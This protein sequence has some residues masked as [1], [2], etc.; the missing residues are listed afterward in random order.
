MRTWL[1]DL[2][3]GVRLAVGGGRTSLVRFVLS[4]IGVSIAVAVLL[5]GA[6]VQ[7]AMDAHDERLQAMIPSST[8]VPGVD[9][10]LMSD[11]PSA[12]R[13]QYLRVRYVHATGDNAPT[14][15]GLPAP[16][17]AGETYVSPALAELLASPD[18]GLLRPRFGAEIAGTIE[19]SA[20]PQLEDLVAY[21]GVD[22]ETM[23]VNSREVYGFGDDTLV[24]PQSAPVRMYTALGAVVFLVPVFVFLATSTR[25]AGAERDRRMAAVRLVGAGTRQVRRITAAESLVSAGAGLAVGGVLFALLRPYTDGLQLL[26]VR[27]RASDIVPDPLPVVLIVVAV[28][29]V[30]F[31]AA[32]FSLRR[33]AI[34]P[35][36]VVRQARPTRR[37]L[38]WRVAVVALGVLLLA[39]GDWL[40]YRSG[41]Y[42][43]FQAYRVAG[44]ALVLLGVPVLLPWVVEF[45][46]RRISGGAPSWQLAIR[47][48][49]LDSGTAG[50]VIAALVVVLAGA[51]AA[52]TAYTSEA[53]ERGAENARQESVASGVSMAT[54]DHQGVDRQAVR[55][56]LSGVTGV[57]SVHE[58]RRFEARVGDSAGD[59]APLG[60]TVLDCA[61]LRSLAI[62]PNCLDG[63]VYTSGVR[64]LPVRLRPGSAV[65]LL[66]YPDGSREVVG[67][68]TL[69]E[70]VESFDAVGLQ[71]LLH[72]PSV[73]A[74]PEALRGVDLPPYAQ[75]SSTVV[76]L[77][78]SRAAIEHVR[79]ALAPFAAQAWTSTA[80]NIAPPG[81]AYAET[82]AAIR[83]ALLTGSAFTLLLAGL[84]LLAVA[85]EQL[86]E[87]RRP[88]AML[89]AS[90]V[91]TGVIARSLLWQVLVPLALGVVIAIGTG[92]G[93]AAVAVEWVR[94]DLLV[95]WVSVGALAG[96][97]VLLSVLVTALTLPFLRSAIRFTSLRTE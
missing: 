39:G 96:I 10:L 66:S 18:G 72:I 45:A 43:A 41:S 57:R 30:A 29:A 47:R 70:R 93:L 94:N 55:S 63:A 36:G 15:P 5:F 16:P 35:L 77:D 33:T 71:A 54:I 52:L 9:P 49:Q 86:R 6:S 21:V 42:L 91:P 7:H 24:A 31:L 87:R 83:A 89:V 78:G 46:T 22:E 40:S 34:E 3:L 97:A 68:W 17:A 13:G 8:A 65:E 80:E 67:T 76:A 92:L 37:R 12:F 85:V 25:I 2:A 62:V 19:A 79:N 28:F 26:D 51:V 38:W 58:Y 4:T 90:G 81:D 1:S 84:S 59:S 14:P 11:Q 60:V 88:L 95:D 74:T 75:E 73:I 56:A 27:V 53:A 61:A 32:Q 23:G 50:R 69:P 20:M 48:L 44:V 64:Y 82:F